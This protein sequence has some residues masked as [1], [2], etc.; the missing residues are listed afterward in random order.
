MSI[1]PQRWAFGQGSRRLMA[2][3]VV[4]GGSFATLNLPASGQGRGPG[5]PQA[6]APRSLAPGDLDVA[7]SRVYIFVPKSGFGHD[8][9]IEGKLKSGRLQLGAAQN[10]GEFVFD[11]PS[12][13]A[14]TAAARRYVGLPGATDAGTRREVNANMLGAD[15]LSVRR[16]PTASFSIVSAQPS[17]QP[18]RRGSIYQLTGKFTLHG[19]TRELKVNAES[20]KV[21]GK[22]HVK[23]SFP[24]VQTHYGIQPFTKALGAVGVANQLTVYAD[25]WIAGEQADNKETTP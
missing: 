23:G 3:T 20:E 15:V 22:I 16:F 12:F 1:E 4:L 6:E 21:Q 24:L 13:D 11:M 9:A 14:D 7:T 5:N 19:T 18:G 10:A 8:H 25:L 17:S 2:L